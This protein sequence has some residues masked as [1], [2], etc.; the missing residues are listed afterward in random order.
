MW[1]CGYSD[2]IK[3]TED[4]QLSKIGHGQLIKAAVIVAG[5]DRLK[6]YLLQQYLAFDHQNIASNYRLG[7]SVAL[8]TS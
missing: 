1:W 5:S 3:S 6:N 7:R 2:V 4:Y 8:H